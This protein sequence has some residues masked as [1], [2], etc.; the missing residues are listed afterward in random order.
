MAHLQQQKTPDRLVTIA[1]TVIFY[2]QCEAEQSVICVKLYV[3]QQSTKL[4]WRYTNCI[5]MCFDDERKETILYEN[6]INIW[7]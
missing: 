5:V 3:H 1:C 6:L 2:W 7:Y 4:K